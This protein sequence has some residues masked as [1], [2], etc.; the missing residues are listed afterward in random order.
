MVN[1]GIF[2]APKLSETLVIAWLLPFPVKFRGTEDLLGSVEVA[3]AMVA[4]TTSVMAN[5]DPITL[6]VHSLPRAPEE[7]SRFLPPAA[8]A[9]QISECGREVPFRPRHEH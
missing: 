2:E 4:L 3:P 5:I 7:K 1:P 6:V 9:R 8:L